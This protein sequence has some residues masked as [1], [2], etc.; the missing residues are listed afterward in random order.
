MRDSKAKHLLSG[1]ALLIWAV[2]VP[3]RAAEQ[4]LSDLGRCKLS[5]GKAIEACRL[6]YRVYGTINAD[7]SNVVLFPSWYNG[8]THDMEQLMGPGGLIDPAKY[9][10]VTIDSLADGVSSSPSKAAADQREL[11]FPMITIGDMV[12]A[13]YRLA[14]EKL[15]FQHVHA[16]VGISMGG[17]QTFE[18]AARYPRFMD[19][20][21]PLMGSPWLTSQDRFTWTI[22]RTAIQND[23]AYQGGHYAQEPVL[24][25]ANELDTLVAYTPAFRV[26]STKPEEFAGF[27]H[28]VDTQPTI[29]A[30]NRVRQMQAIERLEAVDV[31]S[32][33]KLST[34]ELP[35][36]LIVVAR[37]DHTVNPT[38]S[39]DWAKRTGATII[40]LDQD[41]G[42]MSV[43]CAL[44]KLATSVSAMLKP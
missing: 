32:R 30:N 38:P 19:V 29:G 18:W 31:A 12:Q 22:M 3:A 10:V 35:R 43:V 26:R 5:S 2:G 9:Y 7:K 17:M 21:I 28:E 33:E 27:L 11:K 4:Q 8:Q 39:M 20:A 36:M 16:V 37:Q 15:G 13:E 1:L 34:R 25:L 42:H 41:C 23:P 14:T 6:G 44:D 40:E 24:P